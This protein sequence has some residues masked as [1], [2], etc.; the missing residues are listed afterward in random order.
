MIIS[1]F[2]EN[3]TSCQVTIFPFSSHFI[4]ECLLLQSTN[5]CDEEWKGSSLE[6][7]IWHVSFSNAQLFLNLLYLFVLW[8]ESSV[9]L[10]EIGISI[11][12]FKPWG[13]RHL[14]Y[15]K[16]IFYIKFFFSRQ[17]VLFDET[18]FSWM[19]SLLSV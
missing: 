17:I 14:W 15:L 10:I 4:P 9:V 5:L 2:V 13:R 6:Q 1:N 7:T 11:S 16:L 18:H 3:V 8:P 12:D 19:L